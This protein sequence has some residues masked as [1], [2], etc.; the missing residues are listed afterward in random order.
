M[1]K[2]LFLF[3]FVQIAVYSQTF[4]Y[5][6][7]ST[8]NFG[9]GLMSSD[10]SH[11]YIDGRWI[12]K[13][14]KNLNPI[15]SY[16]CTLYEFNGLLLSKTGSLFFYTDFIFGKMDPNGTIIWSNIIGPSTSN[17]VRFNFQSAYLNSS[18]HLMLSGT[19]TVGRAYFLDS[20]TLGNYNVFE[21]KRNSPLPFAF[22]SCYVNSDSAGIYYF[23]CVEDMPTGDYVYVIKI[24]AY[25]NIK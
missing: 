25:C 3:L 6:N 7:A 17:D 1:K 11:Y 13:Y 14:D 5:L 15:W 21:L 16:Y 19:S 12:R 24:V 4:Q 9:E 23:I 20:D 18:N 2:I 22:E 10:S 8:G